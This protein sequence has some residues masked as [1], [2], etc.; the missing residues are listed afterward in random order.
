MF[1]T[2]FG[3]KCIIVH[4]LVVEKIEKIGSLNAEALST[5]RNPDEH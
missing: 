3:E 4:F 2:D 5:L 1:G